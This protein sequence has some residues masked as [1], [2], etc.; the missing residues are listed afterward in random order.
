MG[1]FRRALCLYG[2]EGTVCMMRG[3]CVGKVRGMLGGNGRECALGYGKKGTYGY[4]K[5]DV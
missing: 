3:Y 5:A 4:G 2:R 1:R